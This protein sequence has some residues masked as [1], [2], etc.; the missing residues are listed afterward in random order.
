MTPVF[1]HADFFVF[2]KPAGTSFHSEDGTGCFAQLQANFPD[3]SLFPVHRLDKMTS[4]LLLVARNLHAARQ[5][6]ERF[7]GHAVRK[8]YVAL[9]DHKPTQKQGKIRGDMQRTRDGD[10]KLLRTTSN[11]AITR[12][13]SYSLAPGLRLFMLHPQTGRTHQLRV[14]MKALGSPILGDTRYGG[15][16]ADRGYLHACRLAFDWQGASI[17][18]TAMPTDG[19]LF[20]RY[21]AGIIAAIDANGK[22]HATDHPA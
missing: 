5:F 9:S 16:P 3:E 21:S 4:G 1:E 18:I 10:W 17:T 8:T 22:L 19:E 2:D 15:T 20:T 11:P 7:A 14:M 13:T 6:G 12:F